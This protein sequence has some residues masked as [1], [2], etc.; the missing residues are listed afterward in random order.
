MNGAMPVPSRPAEYRTMAIMISYSLLARA[1]IHLREV[2]LLH[3]WID[4][5][6]LMDAPVN[7]VGI[8]RLHIQQLSFYR[9]IV[10][11]RR[12][13]VRG[14]VPSRNRSPSPKTSRRKELS[15]RRGGDCA[16]Y[17]CKYPFPPPAPMPP[18]LFRRPTRR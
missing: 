10:R 9:P 6:R 3:L 8:L 2:A 5:S 1:E 13:A 17:R 14:V 18:P 12:V 7:A 11:V 4:A 16:K 15:R